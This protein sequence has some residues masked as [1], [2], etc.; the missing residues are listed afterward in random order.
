VIIG[1]GAKILGPINVADDARVSYNSVVIEDVR[2][3]NDS[4]I[5]YI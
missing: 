3:T 2:K 1:A 5:F 4:D